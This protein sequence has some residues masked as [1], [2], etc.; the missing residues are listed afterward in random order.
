MI[1]TLTVNPAVD[2]TAWVPRFQLGEVNRSRAAQLDPAGKGINVSRMAHRLGWPTV[3]FGFLGGHTGDMVQA[4][5]D[6]ERVQSHFVRVPGETRIDV[7][8]VDGASHGSTSLYNAGPKVD[9]GALRELLETLDFWMQAG[10]VL[11]LAGSLAPGVPDDVYAR[12]IARAR[13]HGVRVVLDASGPCFL[14][15]LEARPDVIK[16][17]VREAEALLG[18]P[19]GDR[20]AIVAAAR[21]L[22]ARGLGAA[23]I[24]MGGDGAICATAEAAWHVRPPRVEVQSTVGSGDSM[25][26]GIAVALAR[27][28]PLH[29]GLRLGTAAGAATA[30]RP[31]TA[32]GTADDVARLAPDVELVEL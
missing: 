29:Q 1:L 12:L 10:R 24:S 17:N 2:L 18:R 28:L 5:L 22:V 14:S 25:V 21:E 3:A 16:P 7:T 26:A 6:A 19:L 30:M 4:A 23:V 31:G 9:E 27:A 11:V 13:T 20:A 15:G 8:V 32:L